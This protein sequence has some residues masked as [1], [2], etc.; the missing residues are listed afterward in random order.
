MQH[1]FDNPEFWQ[2]SLIQAIK[3]GT[4]HALCL[5]KPV[6]E[7][8]LFGM[9]QHQLG[10]RIGCRNIHLA[11]LR[12]AYGAAYNGIKA[13]REGKAREAQPIKLSG[14]MVDGGDHCGAEL[15]K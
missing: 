3:W 6:S 11:Q 2:A 8:K 4:T 10:A 5:Q 13:T 15:N 1:H 14:I 9:L 7:K 12:Q